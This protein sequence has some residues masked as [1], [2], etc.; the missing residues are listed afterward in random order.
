MFPERRHDAIRLEA[1]TDE[2]PEE[3]AE[4]GVVGHPVAAAQT[5][6]ERRFEQHLVIDSL[7]YRI[8][9]AA[10]G[11]GSDARLLNLPP[12]TQLAPAAHRGFCMCN[13]LRHPSIVD[14][15][16]LAEP[17]DGS[18]DLVRRVTLARKTLPDLGFGQFTT[19]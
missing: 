15:P 4:F 17:I 8:N 18:V 14:R 10:G 2:I 9:G 19:A 7:E 13:R 12:D 6:G 5:L 16:F 1:L 3:P 11:C